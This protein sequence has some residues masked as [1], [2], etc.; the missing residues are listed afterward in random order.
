MQ[1]IY[2]QRDEQL[3]VFT[4]I[5]SPQGEHTHTLLLISVTT[6]VQN[7]ETVAELWFWCVG[8]IRFQRLQ[9][10]GW[11]FSGSVRQFNVSL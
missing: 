11:T 2:T 5:F 4:T 10:P 9:N 6:W 7:L 3:E 8:G 1:Q